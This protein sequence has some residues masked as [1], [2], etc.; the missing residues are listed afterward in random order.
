MNENFSTSEL[1]VLDAELLIQDG[2][3]KMQTLAAEFRP[4]GYVFLQYP[5]MDNNDQLSKIEFSVEDF[6]TPTPKY[7][8]GTPAGEFKVRATNQTLHAPVLV[9]TPTPT[10]DEILKLDTASQRFVK[11]EDDD[12][13][14]LG[15]YLRQ[16]HVD[17]VRKDYQS[18]IDR[19]K[20]THASKIGRIINYFGNRA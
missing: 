2:L 3:K 15:T 9:E 7:A 18:L 17:E 6:S 13:I 11:A 4:R 1:D 12:V 10:V 16:L 5:Y 14:L 20:R 8:L 19:K